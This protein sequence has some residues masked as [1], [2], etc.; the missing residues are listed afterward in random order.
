LKTEDRTSQAFISSGCVKSSLCRREWR[1]EQI[2]I[3]MC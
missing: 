1:R 3:I 2:S